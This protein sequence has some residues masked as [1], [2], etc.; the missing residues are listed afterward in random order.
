MDRDGLLGRPRAGERLSPAEMDALEQPAAAPPKPAEKRSAGPSG[1][2]RVNV[3]LSAL[4][5]RWQLICPKCGFK[6]AGQDVPKP[7]DRLSRCGG[8]KRTLYLV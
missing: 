7:G 6:V 2:E 1:A 8:C 4:T 3:K 5:W